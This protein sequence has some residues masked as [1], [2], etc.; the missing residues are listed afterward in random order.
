V[1]S[2]TH[3]STE[4]SE[5]AGTAAEGFQMRVDLGAAAFLEEFENIQAL[6]HERS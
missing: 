5:A 6:P 1:L 4:I 2:Q 3:R